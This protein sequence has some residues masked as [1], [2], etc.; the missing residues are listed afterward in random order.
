MSGACVLLSMSENS[1]CATLRALSVDLNFMDSPKD[2]MT[3][4]IDCLVRLPN[5]RTLEI[6]STT[7]LG[8]ITRGLKRK[9]AQF[10]SIRELGISNSTVKFVGS[11]PN[12]ES[13]IV[14]D[15]LSW[16]G[17]PILSSYGKG[18][19]KLRRVV[20]INECYVRQGELRDAFL[21]GTPVY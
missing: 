1:R 4:F 18:L 2:L 15:G 13:I 11:C 9:C 17:A 14:T 8:P 10:P 3:K 5:L 6:F 16:D 7:H 21:S 20:G 19:G 12:V